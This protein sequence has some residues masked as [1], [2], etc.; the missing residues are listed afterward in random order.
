MPIEVLSG[1]DRVPGMHMPACRDIT[2]SATLR[3]PDAIRGFARAHPSAVS[4]A[5]GAITL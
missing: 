4:L 3:L 2:D 5:A 1:G